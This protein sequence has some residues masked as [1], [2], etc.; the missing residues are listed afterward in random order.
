MAG[1]TPESV[2]LTVTSPPYD[3]LRDYQGYEFDFEAIA[4]GVI[5][6]DETRWGGRLGG[7]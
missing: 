7:G 1:M 5:S 2:D 4:T 6:G 3:A